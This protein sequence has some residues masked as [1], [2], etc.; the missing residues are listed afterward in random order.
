MLL[1]GEFGR[2]QPLYFLMIPTLVNSSCNYL[3]QPWYHLSKD[4]GWA[5]VR[6]LSEWREL[7][8]RNRTVRH[9]NRLCESNSVKLSSTLIFLW[10]ICRISDNVWLIF[11]R[12]TNEIII[13]INKIMSCEQ[14]STFCVSDWTTSGTLSFHS[15]D[16][17]TKTNIEMLST[18]Y[19]SFS[20]NHSS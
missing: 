6:V 11:T 17:S 12:D 18:A 9:W 14:A 20:G 16:I 1:I 3:T 10:F 4:E 13:L 19:E 15:I 2:Y 5:L 7:K 8:M